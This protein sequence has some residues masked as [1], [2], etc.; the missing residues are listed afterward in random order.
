M[1]PFLL[2]YQDDP[3]KA[4]SWKKQDGSFYEFFY[5]IK[6]MTKNVGHPSQVFSYEIVTF[7]L[8]PIL[9]NTSTQK[10]YGL[11]YLKNTGQTI[12]TA[13]DYLTLELEGNLVEA[14]PVSY[15]DKIEPGQITLAIYEVDK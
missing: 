5:K 6:D 13:D 3:F 12:W 1:T 14:T 4:F 10:A 2:D 11:M 9:K 15:Q 8:P 7:V